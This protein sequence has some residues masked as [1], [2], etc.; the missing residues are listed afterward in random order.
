MNIYSTPTIV[1]ERLGNG[2]KIPVI[3]YELNPLR[4]PNYRINHYRNDFSAKLEKSFQYFRNPKKKRNRKTKSAIKAK[5]VLYNSYYAKLFLR[6]N[7]ERPREIKNEDG[8]II[9]RHFR[10]LYINSREYPKTKFKSFS[11]R[12]RP[13]RE[14]INYNEINNKYKNYNGNFFSTEVKFNNYLN[15]FPKSINNLK[16]GNGIINYEH[17]NDFPNMISSIKRNNFL[18]NKSSRNKTSKDENSKNNYY[19]TKYRSNGNKTQTKI[20][21]LLFKSN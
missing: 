19:S 1:K 13:F 2:N 4:D 7:F 5:S 9:S 11:F 17:S 10:S 16:N 18:T 21:P 14:K 3:L 20:P 12:N 6:I 15:K 8:V